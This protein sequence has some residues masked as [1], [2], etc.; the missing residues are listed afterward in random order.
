MLIYHFGSREGLIAAIVGRMEARQRATLAALAEEVSTPAELIRRQWAIL[1]HPETLPFV[2][3]FFDVLA[4]AAAGKPGTE[5]F[6]A[7]LTEPW[8]ELADEVSRRFEM[9]VSV[10]ELRLGVAVTRGLLIEV[11][12]AGDP[13]G[14][15]AALEL[16]LARHQGAG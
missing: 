1:T 2:R 16:H 7:T 10:D 8:L 4:Q 3:L 11:L 6:L 13:S 14:P 12:A 9:R 5:G 15:T